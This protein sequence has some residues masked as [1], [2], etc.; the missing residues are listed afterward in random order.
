MK[1]ILEFYLPVDEELFDDARAG[2]ALRGA[3]QE[4]DNWLRAIIKHFPDDRPKTDL[5]VYEECRERLHHA[6]GDL[7]WG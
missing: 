2:T 3:V 7:I 4:Y 6:F 1:A 5:K